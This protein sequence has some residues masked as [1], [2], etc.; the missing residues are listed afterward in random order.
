M[1]KNKAHS[2]RIVW[3]DPSNEVINYPK[4]DFKALNR[5]VRRRKLAIRIAIG[6]TLLILLL[7]LLTFLKINGG[8]ESAAEVPNNTAPY[9]PTI[10]RTNTFDW[11]GIQKIKPVLKPDL[12]KTT[13]TEQEEPVEV[14]PIVEQPPKIAVDRKE[15]SDIYRASI[16]AASDTIQ[17]EEKPAMKTTTETSKDS[18]AKRPNFVPSEFVRA[19]P[20][21]GYD[22][23]YQYLTEFI[24]KELLGSNNESDTLRISFAIEVDGR[25]SGIQLSI[26]TADSVFM[27][28]E[29][30]VQNMPM[31]QPATADGQPIKTRFRLPLIIQSKTIIEADE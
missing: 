29:E 22:S 16:A 27:K 9:G 20:T 3:D 6:T 12:V 31:W 15:E 7:L 11:S 8:S 18:I 13:Q 25:P 28:I 23:L 30:V 4:R 21:V 14:D 1:S 5:R 24:N 19:Y 2:V 17:L 10:N 26:E